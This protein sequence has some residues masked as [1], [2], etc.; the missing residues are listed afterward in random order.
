MLI[1]PA[2]VNCNRQCNHLVNGIKDGSWH[3]RLL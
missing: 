2:R 1:L 3:P